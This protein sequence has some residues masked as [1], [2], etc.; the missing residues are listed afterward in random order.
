[1]E[2]PVLDRL[3][4]D[5]DASSTGLQSLRP[6]KASTGVKAHGSAEIQLTDQAAD[7]A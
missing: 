3:A 5:V 2:T 7:C 1:M 6:Q 4:C